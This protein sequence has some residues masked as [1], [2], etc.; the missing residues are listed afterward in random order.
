VLADTK[1][2]RAKFCK[3]LL[4]ARNRAYLLFLDSKGRELQ[5]VVYPRYHRSGRPVFGLKEMLAAMKKAQ[6]A[7]EEG[8]SGIALLRRHL[9]DPRQEVKLDAIHFL[10]ELGTVARSAVPDL[11]RILETSEDAVLR[12]RVLLA[13]GRIGPDA[14]AAIPVLEKIATREVAEGDGPAKHEKSAAQ[15]ALKKIRP[16]IE[17]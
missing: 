14:K 15:W 2:G 4:V 5:R 12:Y 6:E 9:A 8:L 13:I 16:P 1:N 10:A 11:V 3:K 7:E 17:K